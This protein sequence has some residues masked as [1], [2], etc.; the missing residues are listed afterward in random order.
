MSLPDFRDDGWLPEGR[1]NTNW[2]ELERRFAGEPSSK[3]AAVWGN[4]I[5]WRDRMRQHNITGELLIDGSFISDKEAPGDFDAIFIGDEGIELLLIQDIEARLLLN[6]QVVK[7][8]Y[9][10]DLLFFSKSAVLKFPELCRID[11]FDYSK[12]KIP[13]GVVILPI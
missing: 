9:G 6:Y 8:Y 5:L 7:E 4:L 2:E 12:E 3:R 10:G 13:K 11:G 1:H